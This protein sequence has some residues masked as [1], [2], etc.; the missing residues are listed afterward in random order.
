LGFPREKTVGIP[1]MEIVKIESMT[2][3]E[4]GQRY[5][6][7]FLHLKGFRHSEIS[8]Q[9]SAA[10]GQDVSNPARR[11]DGIHP[12]KIRRTALQT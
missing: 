6:I 7:K 8:T 9:R 11:K 12:F 5:I 1:A 3:M 10:Y 4:L 2:S